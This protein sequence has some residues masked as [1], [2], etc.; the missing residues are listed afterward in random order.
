MAKTTTKPKPPFSVED[1]GSDSC[2]PQDDE[3]DQNSPERI[4]PP[5]I[6]SEARKK[7]KRITKQKRRR[8]SKDNDYIEY[9]KERDELFLSS[10]GKMHKESMQVMKLIA[11][12][13]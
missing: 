5:A 9:L 3:G 1:E 6:I 12:K 7:E 11:D 2:L 13:F 8:A 10:L 4:P